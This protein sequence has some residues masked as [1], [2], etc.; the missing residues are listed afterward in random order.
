MTLAI[1][2]IC[3]RRRFLSSKE[4]IHFSLGKAEDIAR[5]EGGIPFFPGFQ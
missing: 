1:L 2:F 4:S 5:R 3:E